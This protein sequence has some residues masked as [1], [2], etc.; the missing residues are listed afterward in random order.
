MGT[1]F[2]YFDVKTTYVKRSIYSPH[3]VSK[4]SVKNRLMG[5]AKIMS[6]VL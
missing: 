2:Q 1:V 4:V 3:V 5:I 6:A